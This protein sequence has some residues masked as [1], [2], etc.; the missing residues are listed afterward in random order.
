MQ[1]QN[2]F[3]D[4]VIFITGG[5]SGIGLATAAEFAL[6][7]ANVIVCGRR[8]SKW[9]EAQ[10]YLQQRLSKDITRI[11][12]WPCDVRVEKQVQEIIK[13]IFD[14][15]GRVDVCFNNAGVQPG[16]LTNPDSGFIGTMQFDSFID[17][18]G[19]IMYRIPPPQPDSPEK[20]LN[21][22]RDSTQETAASPF[23][24]SEIATSCI[25]VSYCL[26]WEMHYIF[27]SQPKEIPVS[28]INTSSRNGV[29]PDSHRP[30]YA[31]SKAFII[32]M[33]KSIANQVAQKSKR[34]NRQPVRVNA[35]SPGPVDT[36]LEFAAFNT[37]PSDKNQYN[38]YV[39]AAAT[40]VPMQRT[41][42]PEEI[43]PTV[44]FL[45]DNDKS[46]YITGANI[47]IDGGHTGSPLLKS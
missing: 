33:T 47:S 30:L 19:S 26:K 22:P 38:H 10:P 27:E 31:A 20:Y 11:R 6:E 12:Y 23:A 39:N 44:L 18:D 1:N 4:K 3:Q 34:E 45:G 13:K 29:L 42:R 35:I 40:G 21:T 5:T 37:D 41:A 14:E 28:I 25:G 15:F 32:A 46:G 17:Q 24:E 7:G 9:L 8:E 36:P 2:R 43:A 16:I